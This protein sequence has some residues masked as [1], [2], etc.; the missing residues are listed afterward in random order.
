M[1][2]IIKEEVM[3]ENEFNSIIN[4]RI[5]K[6]RETLKRKGK[7][8]SPEED[9]LRH[10]RKTAELTNSTLSDACLGMGMKHIVSII[11]IVGSLS[12]K[13]GVIMPEVIDEKLGD[14][15]NYLLMLEPCIMEDMKINLKKGK[16]K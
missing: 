10:F 11:D 4:N 3:T 9:K 15:I 12:H 13:N 1:L 6:C 16:G 2:K 7:E 5:E 8:Y 14:A